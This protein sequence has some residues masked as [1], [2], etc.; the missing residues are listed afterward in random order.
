MQVVVDIPDDLLEHADPVRETV[1][2]VA[3]A[4]YRSGALTPRQTRELL[5]FETR[6]QLNDFL[7]RHRVFDHAYGVEEYERDLARL[8]RLA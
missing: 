2:A 1:E 6:F 7:V 5:G 4:G 3:I 8:E